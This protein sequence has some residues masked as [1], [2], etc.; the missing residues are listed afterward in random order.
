MQ[1]L[2]DP[3]WIAEQTNAPALAGGHQRSA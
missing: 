1:L 2:A 3:Q